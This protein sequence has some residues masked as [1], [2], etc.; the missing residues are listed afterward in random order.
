MPAVSESVLAA[1]R[2]QRDAP[3]TSPL[4]RRLLDV[5][6]R[7]VEAG[8]PCA[9][10]LTRVDPNLDPVADAVVLRFL[11]GVHRLVLDG[12]APDLGAHYPSAGGRFDPDEPSDRIAEL[13]A[14]F[15]EV[16]A[17]HRDELIEA[18]DRGIQTNEVGRC[19]ALL[20]GFLEVASRCGL[21]LRVLELGASAGLNLRWD[22]YRYEGGE[23]GTAW[24][25]PRSPLRLDLYAEPRPMLDG[26]AVV[27]ER[28]GCDRSPL[29]PLRPDGRL[30]LRSFVWPDQVDRLSLLDAAIEVARTVPAAVDEADAAEWLEAQLPAPTPGAATVVYHS[31]VWQYLPSQSRS[32]IVDHLDRIGRT[33]STSAPVAWLRLEPGADPARAAEVRLTVWPDGRQRVV[34][35]SG[36]HLGP[37]RWR[38]PAIVPTSP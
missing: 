33:A 30:A 13:S 34:A 11:G 9:A 32:G 36:Y 37:V 12:R 27:V 25:D 7:D 28:R 2:A 1:V 20:V 29:D 6:V 15:L 21:P 16:V 18:L 10:V 31:I 38:P 3:A 26:H 23:A 8:G 14:A 24:G 5:T 17:D 4:Y 19:A 35:R 22:H